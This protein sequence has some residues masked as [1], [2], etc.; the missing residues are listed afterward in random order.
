MHY[1]SVPCAK[2][3]EFFIYLWT[4]RERNAEGEDM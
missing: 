4:S 3:I 1:Q 2:D